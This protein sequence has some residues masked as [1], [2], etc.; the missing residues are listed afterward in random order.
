M[1]QCMN[2]GAA[3]LKRILAVL[4]VAF[5]SLIFSG[6]GLREDA[7]ALYKQEAPLT[8]EIQ[9][10]PVIA[11]GEQTRIQ[12]VLAQHGKKV[13]QSDFVHIEIQAQ[14]GSMVLPMVETVNEGNGIYSFSTRFEQDG[15]YYIRIHAGNDGSLVSPL[16]RIAVGELSDLEM[17]SLKQGPAKKG[18]PSGHH[19]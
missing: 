13:E 16:K 8:V 5:A 10:E 6:C 15:L 9:T 12:V 3:T 7:A 14:D 19:H 2:K 17:E 11:P 1:A 18:A 4:L